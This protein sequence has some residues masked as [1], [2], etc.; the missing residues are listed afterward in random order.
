MTRDEHVAWA[1]ERA[2]EYLGTNDLPNAF[3]SMASDLS[4]HPETAGVG[5]VM[6]Q[7]GMLHVINHDKAGLRHWI[8]G[9]N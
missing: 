1:K 4:K 5:Q 8:E 3:T 9:F 6:G 2:L 7:M